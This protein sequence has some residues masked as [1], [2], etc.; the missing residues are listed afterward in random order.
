MILKGTIIK[1]NRR[2]L[3]PNVMPLHLMLIPALVLV[4][5][6]NYIPILGN[7]I[8]FQ[9]F[10]I[11][12]G[13]NGI[14][15]GNEWVGLKHFSTVFKMDGFSRAL[16]NTVNISF[17]KM[18]TMFV[19]PLLVSLL[20]NEMRQEYL[21]KS[22]QTLIY[23]PHFLS[24]VILAGILKQILST[25]GLI[26]NAILIPL[27]MEPM[28]FLGDKNLFPFIVIITNIWKEFGWSTIIYL[29]AITSIDPSLYEAAIMDG[30][31]KLK[32]SWHVT[33]P[34]MKPIIV[35]SLVLSL[36]SVLNAG[37]E[38]IFNL[39]SV[40]VYDT[41]DILD[42]LVYR[43]SFANAQYD[44]ATA[45]GLF[46]NTVSF[47]FITASYWLAYRFANYEIF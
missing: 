45:V 13:V 38:Q 1:R 22:I 26:N 12:K 35:L 42:T 29:A 5:I 34:G 6:Y 8:A 17:W 20:L 37:F 46:K 28:F 4:I 10:D 2:S 47:V 39:Y 41:G 15:G 43:M 16:F 14:L 31:N 32:Q 27:D 40:Q 30:A 11:L 25:D 44:L 23:L 7:I 18:A 19:V 3:S 36:G 24:W 21:K 9:K 33:L